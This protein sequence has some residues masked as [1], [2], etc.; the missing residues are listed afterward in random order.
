MA[1]TTNL[2]EVIQRSEDLCAQEAIH[3]AGAIQPHGY[4]VGLNGKTLGL[5]TRSDNLDS[6]FGQ[7]VLGEVPPWLSPPLLEH[8]RQMQAA[9]PSERFL[10]AEFPRLGWVELH[11]FLSGETIFCEFE[12]IGD[13]LA[14]IHSEQAS[15]STEL[16]LRQ[17]S[18]ITDL[19]ELSA[20]AA[21]AIR[22]I[23]GFERVLVYR[24][25][26]EGHGDVLGESLS[27][28]WD[29]S[30]LGLRFPASDIPAQARALY[31]LT[32]DRWIPRRDYS[33]V[34]LLPPTEEG[35]PFDIGH[36]RYRSVSPVHRLYQRNIGV[37]GAMSVSVMCDGELWGLVIGHHRQ[38]H[39]VAS[40][41]R[42]KVVGIVQAFS[43]RLNALTSQKTKA[44][45]EHDLHAYSAT[46][47]KLAGADDFLA[48][49][50]EGSPN[51]LELLPGCSGAAVVWEDECGDAMVRQ[52]GEALPA[53]D[54]IALVQWVR[55]QAEGLVFATATLSQIY[56][57]FTAHQG[58]A[59]GVLAGILNDDPRHPVLLFF[60]PEEIHEVTW[61]G[62]PEKLAGEDG[63]PVL[64]RRS[65]DRWTEVKRGVSKPWLDW[66]QEV[67]GTVCTTVSDVILRQMRR[68]H[69]LDVEINRFAQA[70]T[71][72]ATTLYHQD[73]DLRYLWVFNPKIGFATK[74]VGVYEHDLLDAELAARVIPIKQEVLRSGQGQRVEIASRMN[75]PDTEWFDLS[76]EPLIDA[77]GRV[78][79]LSCAGVN[80]TE[81][82]QTELQLRDA[83]QKLEDQAKEL[84]RSNADLEQFAYATSHDLRQPLRAI[85]SH[86]G[87][88]ERHLQGRLDED[89]KLFID[90][91]VTGGKR[92]DRMIVD[93]LEY[94]RVGRSDR[95][96]ERV[97]LS[98][99][100]AD[101]L[102]MLEAARADVDGQLTLPDCLPEVMGHAMELTRLFQNLIGNALKYRAPDRAP[103][104]AVG[105]RD[106]G[107]MW[108]LQ[109]QDNGIGIAAKDF[110]RAFGV[111]QRLTTQQNYEGTGIGLSICKK[112]VESHDG[113]IWIT[114]TPGQGSC[115]HLTLPKIP[116][117][118]EPACSCGA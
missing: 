117:S 16:T 45:Q 96:P 5:V 4:L 55:Q 86:V 108:E 97:K 81:R 7:A 12:P 13:G 74:T 50:T 3:L 87:L 113:R 48:A 100:L 101:C 62:K 75:D 114:S 91:A 112:I 71:L 20:F 30:F 59:S 57:P 28:D 32:R 80:I 24:F 37:D 49:L 68:I 78:Y 6:V 79:G 18:E 90:T 29:Q 40:L 19:A 105:C 111:F 107:K 72:S 14:A 109:V 43:L 102:F 84:E 31:R 38:P 63:L 77:E 47:R 58:I 33:E 35:K 21:Q 52:L 95:A 70:L 27:P 53:A 61:A 73:R 76:I 92:M 10:L 26:P 51:I 110:D 39:A 8:L 89:A 1:A 115:F 103:V 15:L 25:D 22:A 66:E 17:M 93:L 54:V 36:S 34:P 116:T 64:P 46:L 94:S 99:V 56:P 67:V 60:R 23:S 106:A 41:I 42:H 65:F 9:G 11:C 82:M 2:S 104:I 44:D 85:I 98:D 88:L 118:G 83:L 69:E